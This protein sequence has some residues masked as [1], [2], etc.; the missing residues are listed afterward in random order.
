M[1]RLSGL[2]SVEADVCWWIVDV[3]C[4][5][6]RPCGGSGGGGALVGVAA[7]DEA[8]EEEGLSG[9]DTRTAD[10]DSGEDTPTPTPDRAG[11]VLALEL[12]AML[13]F[14][15]FRLIAVEFL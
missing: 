4:P 5:R 12:V 2:A 3:E 15:D 8:G 13:V 9:D 14:G 1:T 7:P 6:G 10:A 11:L